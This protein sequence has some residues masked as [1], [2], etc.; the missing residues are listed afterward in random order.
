MCLRQPGALALLFAAIAIAATQKNPIG[1]TKPSIS[2]GR[3]IFIRN[4]AG[5]HGNDAKALMDAGGEATDLTSPKVYKHGSTEGEI[6]A[7][8]RD[9]ANGMPAFKDD[10]KPDDIWNVVN[11]IRSL[12]PESE[13]PR[14]REK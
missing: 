11:F 13:R 12:W 2:R 1:N 7:S 14:L 6:F 3:S 5:C 4:C 9:G 8:I 10:L